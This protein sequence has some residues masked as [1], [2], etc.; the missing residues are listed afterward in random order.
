[1]ESVE[2]NQPEEKKQEEK[3]SQDV[4]KDKPDLKMTQ[5]ENTESAV[6]DGKP[7]PVEAPVRSDPN[8]FSDLYKPK[9]QP[10]KKLP[11]SLFG[12]KKNQVTTNAPT[13]SPGN[14]FKNLMQKATEHREQEKAKKEAEGQ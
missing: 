6:E 14:V 5:P 7:K 3:P 2:N 8:M 10:E 12:G 1:M 13:Q 11:K 4:A 9:Q